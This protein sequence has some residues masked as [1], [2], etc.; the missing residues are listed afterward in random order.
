MPSLL[1]TPYA[2]T[3]GSLLSTGDTTA[4]ISPLLITQPDQGQVD[5][6]DALADLYRKVIG[7]PGQL[8]GYVQRQ[9]QQAQDLGLWTGGQAWEGGHPTSRGLLDVGQQ[10]G[11][12]I[13]GTSVAPGEVPGL[14]PNTTRGDQISTRIPKAKG[15][16]SDPHADDSL[17]IN[18]DIMQQSPQQYGRNADRIRQYPGIQLADDASATDAHQALIAFSKDN[19]RWLYHSV[20][21]AIRDQGPLWYD[22]AHGI[23]HQYASEYDVLPRQVAG[24]TAA[25]SPQNDWNQNISMTKRLLD[26]RRDQGDTM[27]TPEMS[28]RIMGYAAANDAKKPA[29][30]EQ[31]RGLNDKFQTT[32][33]GELSDPYEQAVW[34]RAY[35]EA[36]NSRSYPVWS[37]DG[38]PGANATNLDGSETKLG[39]GGFDAIGKAH[40]ILN[41]GS[42]DNISQQLGD[43]HK[44]RNFYNNIIDPS[45]PRH[46]TIDTHAIAAAHLQPLGGS[47]PIVD[48]GLGSG[49]SGS[50]VT[51]ARGLY[52]AY[53]DA[54]RQLAAELGILPRQLQS[55]T[56]E[57]VRGLFTPAQKRD[58]AL[59]G[60]VENIWRRHANGEFDADTARSLIHQRAGG[61]DQPA[62]VR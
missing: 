26:I 37:P 56:W 36:H 19:L 47:H 7:I 17:I 54:Y 45:D 14:L 51:G 16:D 55:V 1:D 49:G 52:G 10:V 8:S 59:P 58:A 30:A 46:V 32:R 5:Q 60:D 27:M 6:A 38:T 35:D 15:L 23:S 11:D 21:D 57:G 31:L 29:V 43:A 48:V 25:L 53:A 41:D 44:V 34:S 33:F 4:N 20:P 18:H 42:V 24:A 12:M 40:A 9:Q 28:D 39:W 13:L 61:I 62:W 22:G 50:D 2:T 3:P